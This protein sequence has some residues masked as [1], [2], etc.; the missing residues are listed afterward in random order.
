MIAN[1]VN[2]VRRAFRRYL[3]EF[4]ASMAAYVVVICIRHWLLFGPMREAGEEW[5]TAVALLPFIPTV[6][7]FA[8]VVRLL[9]RTD[10]LYRRICID[11]LAI[12]GGATAL[13]AITYG[14]IES[15]QFPHLSAW[16]TYVT[17]M[18]AWLVAQFFVRRQY[19]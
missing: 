16:W 15:D 17:F 11:S 3:F 18:M 2:P 14:L 6:F 8:A 12:A 9:R 7:V 4:G 5:R 19:Q 13:L 10:E 1:P